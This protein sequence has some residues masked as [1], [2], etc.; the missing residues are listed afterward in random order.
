MG[1]TIDLGKTGPAFKLKGVDGKM[2]SLKDYADKKAV[3]IVFTCNHCPAAIAAEDRLIA[4]Q[5]DYAPKGVA[6]VAINSNED[7]GHPTDSFEHMVKRAAEKKFNFP[8]L[9]DD[10]QEIAKAYGAL[11][12]P[13]AFVLDAKQNVVYRGRVD[14][15][16][17]NPAA[18][19]RHDLREA[20]DEALAGKP[21]TVPTTAPVGCN[22]KW[23]GKDAHWMPTA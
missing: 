22:V 9:R 17:D 15:N 6:L 11:R 16:I 3:V 4:I 8:Y 12:T 10:T 21:V 5:R 2:H 19:T 14:D 20:I 18:V 13:H 23:W 1:F 7:V